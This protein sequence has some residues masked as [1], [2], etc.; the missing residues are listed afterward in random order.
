M[1]RWLRSWFANSFLTYHERREAER[2]RFG[3]PLIRPWL[4]R[5]IWEPLLCELLGR[6][7]PGHRYYRENPLLRYYPGIITVLAIAAF[8]MGFLRG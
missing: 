4:F 7:P 3:C 2:G 6:Y 8:I 5:E 1:R